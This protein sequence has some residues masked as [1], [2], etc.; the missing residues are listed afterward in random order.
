MAV[1]Q[2]RPLKG[3]E[4]RQRHGV[5]GIQSQADLSACLA[6]AEDLGMDPL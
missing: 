5:A 4:H 1:V 3:E 6:A 2:P